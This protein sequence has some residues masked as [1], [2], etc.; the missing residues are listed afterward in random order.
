MTRSRRVAAMYI[1]RGALVGT[2]SVPSSERCGLG[3]IPCGTPSSMPPAAFSR[4]GV[5][6]TRCVHVRCSLQTD[7]DDA[8]SPLFAVLWSVAREV[9]SAE[10][11]LALR[12]SP[13][14]LLSRPWG[15]S[16]LYL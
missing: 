6:H 8:A 4:T 12:G 9:P 16:E 7:A 15:K 11:S 10:Q 3:V 2:L 1:R 5:L 14:R 13:K